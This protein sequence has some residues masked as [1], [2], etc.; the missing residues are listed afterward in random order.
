MSIY[1]LDTSSVIRVVVDWGCPPR[2]TYVCVQV[3]SMV[4]IIRK[5]EVARRCYIAT[6]TTEVGGLVGW[7]G[8]PNIR[9]LT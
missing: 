3:I 5:E 9:F 6:K 8:K 2:T 4:G 1:L 7:M